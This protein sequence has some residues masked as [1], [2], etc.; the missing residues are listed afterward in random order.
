MVVVG[1]VM[2]AWSLL[3]VLLAGCGVLGPPA[4]TVQ[5]GPLGGGWYLLTVVE[6]W[7]ADVERVC[8]AGA[9]GCWRAVEVTRDGRPTL[10]HYVYV[11]RGAPDPVAR[12]AHESCHA[13]A[14]A[15]GIAPDPC[16]AHGTGD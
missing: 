16:H 4:G 6:T 10:A 12:V 1:V 15:Q 7:P 9:A 5:R 8:G 14:R 3:A 13:L 11:A 2:L